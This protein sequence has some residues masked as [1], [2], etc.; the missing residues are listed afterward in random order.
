MNFNKYERPT[1]K[2]N[3]EARRG[4]DVKGMWNIQDNLGSPV[5]Y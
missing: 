1:D 5:Y 4:A 3:I 2:Y